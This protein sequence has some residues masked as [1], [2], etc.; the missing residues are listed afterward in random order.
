MKEL[1]TK[2]DDN[3][4]E[5]E[6]QKLK[7]RST[8]ED[9]IITSTPTK[10]NPFGTEQQMCVCPFCK[11][12]MFTDIEQEVS[13]LGIILSIIFLIIFKIYGIILIIFLIKFTQNT[14]HSCPNCLNKVG[15]HSIF[16]TL[17]LKDKV[18]TIKFSNFGIIITKKH[19]FGIIL[20]LLF[21]GIL[22]Y[23]L[24]TVS[25][26]KLLVKETWNEF[27][28]I[29]TENEVKCKT[30]FLYQDISWIGFVIRVNFNDNFFQR[31]RVIFLVKMDLDENVEKTDLI[32]EV[33]DKIYNKYKIDI[34]NIT[35]GD[36]I[37]FNATIKQTPNIYGNR[38]TYCILENIRL[39]G[40]NFHVNPHI[41][42]SGR[43]GTKGNEKG[44]NILQG[45]PDVIIKKTKEDVQEEKN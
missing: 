43:Y 15:I 36:E 40:R 13:W 30:K 22:Y 33:T 9:N 4:K 3:Y 2:K 29:C 34:M 35:R 17:T 25:F 18:F 20:F 8:I 27:K 7:S 11:V 31:Q 41:H 5:E 21:I 19:L 45:L 10:I 38:V 39:T 26:S 6:K 24:R 23:I 44:N 42:E 16:D 37:E 28:K 1:T 14:I 12:K 32:L